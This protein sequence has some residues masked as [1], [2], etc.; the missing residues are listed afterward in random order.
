MVILYASEYIGLKGESKN[1]TISGV[2]QTAKVS[3]LWLGVEFYDLF[4]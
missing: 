4:L 2:A 3:N 1:L